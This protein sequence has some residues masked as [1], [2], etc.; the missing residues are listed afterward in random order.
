MLNIYYG[1]EDIDKQRFLFARIAEQNRVLENRKP[2]YLIVPDQFTLETERS[3]F[4]YLETKGFINPVVISLNRLAA[5]VLA[6]T[7]QNTEHID[8][9]G[10]YMLIARLLHAE[11]D[12]LEIYRH[13]EHSAAFIEKLSD[14]IMSLKAH[15]VT[16]ETLEA[17]ISSL[18]A[19]SLLRRKCS[20]LLRVYR[21]YEKALAAGRPDSSDIAQAF[22]RAIPGSEMLRDAVV[23]LWGYD[24][25]APVQEAQL[26]QMA[27]RCAE[28][29][30]VLTAEPGNPLFTLTNR[31]ADRLVDAARKAGAEAA[32][33][34][35]REDARARGIDCAFRP[36]D[37]R[38]PEIRHIER[39]LYT[40]PTQVYAEPS[41][42][43]ALAFVR[44]AN[45]D[46]EAEEAAARITDLVR[47]E[48][49]RYR[50]ILVLCNDTGPLS[51][52]IE[53]VFA[54]WNLPA[55]F[56]RRRDVDHNP[57]LEY[58]LAL[59]EI[60][61][62]GRRV[63]DVFRWVRTGLVPIET[64]DAEELENYALR[65]NLRGNAWGKPL[66]Y[67][68][69]AFGDERFARIEETAHEIAALVDAFAAHFTGEGKTAAARANGLRAYLTEDA[70]LPD[71]ID[72]LAAELEA[73]GEA[74]YA[75]EMRG[76]W[77][78]VQNLFDQII[79]SLGSLPMDAEEFAVVLRAGFSSVKMG[80]LPPT[81]DAVTVGTTQRTRTGRAKAIFVLGANDGLLPLSGTG[82]ELI[83]AA[84]KEALEEIG[85][86]AF[87]S[88]SGLLEEERLAIYKNLTKPTRLLYL[89]CTE[90]DQSGKQIAPSPVFRRL[91]ALFPNVPV[92][93]APLRAQESSAPPR[94]Y[95]LDPA[96]LA[97]LA[98][99]PSAAPP[100]DAVLT[101]SPSALESYSRCPFSW[102]MDR[103]VR[104]GERRVFG[105]DGRSIGELYHEALLRFEREMSADGLAPSDPE[106][107]WQSLDDAEIEA[108]VSQAVSELRSTYGEGLFEAGPAER[109]RGTR[110]ERV[111]LDA[112]LWLAKQVRETKPAEMRFE[113]DF[114]DI[115]IAQAGEMELRV[116]GRIDRYDVRPDG[117]A[118]VIDYKS[119]ADRFRFDEIE[120]GWR[121]QLMLY[122]AAVSSRHAPA[123]AAYIRLFE[124]QVDLSA[125]NAPV[126]D[127]QIREAFFKQFAADGFVIEKDTEEEGAADRDPDKTAGQTGRRK[128]ATTGEYRIAPKDYEALQANVKAVLA[129]IAANLASGDVA[130]RPMES[131]ASSASGKVTACTWCRFRSVCGYDPGDSLEIPYAPNE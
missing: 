123:G 121:L 46:R 77:D 5:R 112:C 82:D 44:A 17:A 124:P 110:M 122:L 80:V 102:L 54:A 25:L 50:D 131:G 52:A 12:Q 58:I 114:K 35:V 63:Q 113:E 100:T 98:T 103:G 99:P 55:F 3:A 75:A 71:R 94:T 97:A 73:A 4:D 8:R 36:Q 64:G 128:R 105:A 2:I 51:A 49:C 72:E 67:G 101:L 126:T 93:K 76:V 30:T 23:W 32:K 84:E 40:Y 130:A 116:S 57:V 28:V 21:G 127:E 69:E 70:K 117:G 88:E 85:L 108:F 87:R 29:N 92:Q 111:L 79:L 107:R 96:L 22:V 38:P 90:A 89:S 78:V 129:E 10:K 24:Y 13:F 41:S 43:A 65:Y 9:Y 31:T 119:G 118:T 33:H 60:V 66:R 16:P 34:S 18:E 120:S 1:R 104:L 68:R 39:A 56:D 20:D 115:K 83:G 53:R 7:G 74:D 47:G 95:R 14:A 48:G 125:P 11:G 15:L 37:E 42:L 45:A 62:R 61:A 109:Y 27:L 6:E 81:S 26:A 86:T 106:S 59:P 91:N 19:D